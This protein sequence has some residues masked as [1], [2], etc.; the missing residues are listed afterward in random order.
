MPS[1]IDIAMRAAAIAKRTA[2]AAGD[3]VD[4]TGARWLPE[5]ASLVLE[6]GDSEASLGRIPG[7]VAYWFGWFAFYPNTEVHGVGEAG[8]E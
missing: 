5:E 4:E 3:L 8:A 1:S 7:H 6:G 2:S